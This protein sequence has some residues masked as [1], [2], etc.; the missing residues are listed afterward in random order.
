MKGHFNGELW[1][2]AVHPMKDEFITVGEDFMLY[3]WDIKARK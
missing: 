2:L 1:G 3:K